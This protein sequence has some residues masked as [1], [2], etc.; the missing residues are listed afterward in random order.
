MKQHKCQHMS[1]TNKI[2]KVKLQTCQSNG[3]TSPSLDKKH[4]YGN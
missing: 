3:R 1:S 2:G 4:I